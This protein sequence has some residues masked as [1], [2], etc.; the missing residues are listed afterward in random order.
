[1]HRYYIVAYWLYCLIAY[2]ILICC[3]LFCNEHV[4]FWEEYSLIYL[5]EN[6]HW[7]V[8][9]LILLKLLNLGFY[10]IVMQEF[11]DSWNVKLWLI[12]QNL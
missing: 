5:Q 10:I 1:M 11:A 8:Q 3:L 12:R 9:S 7:L 2:L 6:K 4:I